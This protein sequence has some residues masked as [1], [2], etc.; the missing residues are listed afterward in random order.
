MSPDEKYTT[1][2]SEKI[3]NVFASGISAGIENGKA[4]G[5]QEE[6]KRLWDGI[7]NK[8]G[9]ANYYYAFCYN[10]M[11]DEEYDPLY[12]IKCSSGTTPSQSIFYSNTLITDTKV[13]VRV[14][15]N[16]SN[17]FYGMENCHTIHKFTC[18]ESTTLTN[19]FKGMKNL[20]NIE[21]GGTIGKNVSFEDSDKLSD[22]SIDSIIEHLS[23]AT[24][25]RT[26]TVHATVYNKMVADGKDALVTA[27]NWSL[28]K[29]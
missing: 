20:V 14:T 21:I 27:K 17:C 23:N 16:A 11:S 24:A 2:T 26:L 6:H 19:A 22:A 28:V 3:P 18:S 25:S 7:Q 5:K 1:L 29:G 15:D 13:E 12:P 4:I 10:R 9:Y 8:G